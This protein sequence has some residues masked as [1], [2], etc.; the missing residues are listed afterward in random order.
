MRRQ[1]PDASRAAHH[2][3]A[4]SPSADAPIASGRVGSGSRDVNS[5]FRP[6]RAT[7]P[8]T[9]GST[10]HVPAPSASRAAQLPAPPA[11]ECA[12]GACTPRWTANRRADHVGP[13]R[14]RLRW[15]RADRQRPIAH[16]GQSPPR[17][18]PTVGQ[19][20]TVAR[21]VEADTTRSAGDECFG[22]VFGAWT[23]ALDARAAGHRAPVV[24]GAVL[25]APGG[26]DWAWRL[27]VGR[28][29]TFVLVPSWW[30]AGVIVRFPDGLAAGGDS[31]RG[32]ATALVADGRV[33]P[34]VAAAWLRP[35]PCRT[36]TG[37][38]APL[39]RP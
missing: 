17:Q 11:A 25:H 13:C 37:I 35:V 2:A 19:S 16:R 36:P 23:P 32:T 21:P 39:S 5:R 3:P 14:P 38:P 20:P 6:P 22:F 1:I 28:D 15:C 24:D 27:S 4:P 29:T 26:R 7:R 33:R 31:A 34:P 18:S 12:G 10:P 8:A 9:R 30:P